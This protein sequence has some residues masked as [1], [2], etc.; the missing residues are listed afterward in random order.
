MRPNAPITAPRGPN[1][2]TARL[3]GLAAYPKS[4]TEAPY[5]AAVGSGFGLSERLFR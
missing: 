3:W 2:E 5:F 4:K 1:R